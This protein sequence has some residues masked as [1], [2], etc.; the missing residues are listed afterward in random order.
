MSDQGDVPQIN[1]DNTDKNRKIV[2]KPTNDT[3]SIICFDLCYPR[4]SLRC[5]ASSRVGPGRAACSGLS[6]TSCLTFRS[7]GNARTR[8]I[9]F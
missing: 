2:E 3:A 6:F 5:R 7:V 9:G 4:L 1:T 8:W